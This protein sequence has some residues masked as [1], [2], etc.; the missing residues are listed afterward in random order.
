MLRIEAIKAFNRSNKHVDNLIWDTNSWSVEGVR[1]WHEWQRYFTW[2]QQPD[3]VTSM[4]IGQKVS[5]AQLEVLKNDRKASEYYLDRVEDERVAKK[6]V[7][8]LLTGFTNLRKLHVVNGYLMRAH[9]GFKKCSEF[10]HPIQPPT[11]LYRNETLN[12]YGRPA[13]L[14]QR[15]GGYAFAFFR[16]L[17]SMDWSLTKLR[18]DA[19]CWSSF[20]DPM[21]EFPSLKGVTSLHLAVT[22]RIDSH[23]PDYLTPLQNKH[24]LVCKRLL[25]PQM[26]FQNGH[27]MVFLSRLPKLRS[28]KLA[29][30]GPFREAAGLTM[31]PTM[32]TID[33]VFPNN[34]TWPDLEKLV[35]RNIGTR[36]DAL[37]SL[38]R[39]QGG[40]LKV[41]GLHDINFEGP[42]PKLAWQPPQVFEEMQNV[43]CLARA[44]LSGYFGCGHVL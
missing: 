25:R 10:V 27:L 26:E 39:R 38:M 23:E 13:G 29:F 20:T 30:D 21:G 43:L 35:L 31:K 16:D 37:L 40:T 4:A 1:D 6:K 41:L 24:E 12:N 2:R 14:L 11:T 5:T 22:L 33:D 9:R 28:L 7:Q 32:T 42:E 18:M 8:N 19:V 3:L 17:Q 36:S 15:P 44:E 34:Y